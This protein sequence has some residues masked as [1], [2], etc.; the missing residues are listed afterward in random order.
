[1]IKFIKRILRKT[2]YRK[3]DPKTQD[4]VIELCAY[5]HII[6]ILCWCFLGVAYIFPFIPLAI[7]DACENISL[8]Q[9]LLC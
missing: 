9:I 4:K 7:V 3:L 1:M 8:S 5:K 2:L 6:T